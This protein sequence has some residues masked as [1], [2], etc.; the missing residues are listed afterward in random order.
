MQVLRTVADAVRFARDTVAGSKNVALVP[1]MGF[2]HPGHLSLMR[3]AKRRA[4]VT[5]VSIFV[6]PTQFG[7]KED[8]SRYPRDFM[9][10][11]AKCDSVGVDVVFAPEAADFY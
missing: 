5:V 8:L 3:E 10:D 7:P 6:N 1:T 9:G 4:S 2:L 11:L